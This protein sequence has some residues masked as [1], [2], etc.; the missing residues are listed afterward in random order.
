MRAAGGGA[1][2]RSCGG[3]ALGPGNTVSPR[4]A[5]AQLADALRQSGED[6]DGHDEDVLTA[7][8]RQITR[9]PTLCVVEDLDWATLDLHHQLRR[10]ARLLRDVPVVV[11]C[12]LRDTDSPAV[13]GLL[14]ELALLG[15]A[16][17]RL[18][19]LT[20][21]EVAEVLAARGESRSAS[22]SEELHRRSKGTRSSWASC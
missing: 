6:A 17:P 7:L 3:H 20:T 5:L 1:V 22:V 15:T 12:A 9:G 4:C 10:L 21:E 13:S 18:D 14:V 11:V 2:T 16:W 8:V 19:A